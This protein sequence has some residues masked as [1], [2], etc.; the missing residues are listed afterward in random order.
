MTCVRYAARFN[1]D[2]EAIF[3]HVQA[4]EVRSG[5]TYVRCPPRPPA[6]AAGE[7]HARGRAGHAA[8]PP[9]NDQEDVG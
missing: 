1:Y 2:V 4:E 7:S 6:P 5:L 8:A 9:A 3:R